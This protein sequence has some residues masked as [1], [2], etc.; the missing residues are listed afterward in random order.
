MKPLYT[1][2]R[3]LLFLLSLSLFLAS[4]SPTR[5][6]PQAW[7]DFPKDGTIFDKAGL[8]TITAHAALTDGIG[9]VSLSANGQPIGQAAPAEKGALFSDFNLTW[10]PA[11]DGDYTLVLKLFDSQ[12]AERASAISRVKIG[13]HITDTPDASLTPSFTPP[14]TAT[15]TPTITATI[16]ATITPTNTNT[17]T[18]TITQP[19][20]ISLLF[21]TNLLTIN[22]GE[23]ATLNWQVANADRVTLDNSPVQP[24]GS[25][26]ACPPTTQTYQ[27]RAERGADYKFETITITV[28]AADTTPPPVPQPQV[29]ANGL[30]IACKAQQTLAWL[31]VSDPSGL[32][33]YDL[34]LQRNA[35]TW[36]AF[37]NWTSLGDKQVSADI[38]CGLE[39]RWRVRAVDSLGNA[40]AWSGWS[41]FAVQLN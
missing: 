5:Y 41:T 35:G 38:Q 39:F 2:K 12:G 17:P 20:P 18:P 15:F 6:T 3:L 23:C 28:N 4:C 30:Q 19:P 40:S 24:V 37:R 29:P 13:G 16:H 21:V 31:P 10:N 27:L 22:A 34:E 11:G 36:Q 14:P 26:S 33:G 32:R 25:F 1:L 7:I 9:Y 8:I